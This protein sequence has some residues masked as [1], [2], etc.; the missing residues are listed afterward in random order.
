MHRVRGRRWPMVVA[1]CL[2]GVACFVG[3][4]IVVSV[5]LN[6]LLV[7]RVVSIGN[8]QTNTASIVVSTIVYALLLVLLLGV[9]AV[10]FRWR[11]SLG[12]LGLSRPITWSDYPIAI[13]GIVVYFALASVVLWMADFLPWVN[14][15]QAQEIGIVSP[16]PSELIQAFILLVV[17]APVVE[18]IIFRGYLY[19]E[20]RR[21]GVS[22]WLTTLIVSV[23]FGVAHMQWNVGISIFVLSIVMCVARE[24]THSIWPSILMHMLKNGIAYYALFIIGLHTGG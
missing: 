7:L 13:L 24:K 16:N 10:L 12:N 3:A 6:T 17:V 4:Q 5:V 23:L 1:V 22:F 19:G 2:W 18:E 21:R 9:P 8:L 20:I 14:I 15:N 11:T